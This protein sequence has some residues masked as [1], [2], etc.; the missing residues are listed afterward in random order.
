MAGTTSNARRISQM[1]LQ[2][3]LRISPAGLH[4]PVAEKSRMISPGG[5]DSNRDARF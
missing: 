4:C 5:E 2:K 1:Y 3:I